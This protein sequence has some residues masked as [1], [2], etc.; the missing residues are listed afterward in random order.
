MT[1]FPLGLVNYAGHLA[2]LE[3]DQGNSRI[4]VRL[5]FKRIFEAFLAPTVPSSFALGN[6]S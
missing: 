3:V 4:L 1:W 6:R 5:E 2:R